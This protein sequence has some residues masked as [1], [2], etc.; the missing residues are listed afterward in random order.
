[1][2]NINSLLPDPRNRNNIN[3]KYRQRSLYLNTSNRIK[4]Y[5]SPD[6]KKTKSLQ[7]IQSDEI[8]RIMKDDPKKFD[9]FQ[10]FANPIIANLNKSEYPFDLKQKIQ[11]RISDEKIFGQIIT[12]M[13]QVF[14]KDIRKLKKISSD[15]LNKI[16][17]LK[18]DLFGK[19]KEEQVSP[20]KQSLLQKFKEFALKIKQKFKGQQGQEQQAELITDEFYKIITILQTLKQDPSS[21]INIALVINKFFTIRIG[22]IFGSFPEFKRDGPLKNL[23]NI[24]CRFNLLSLAVFLGIEPLIVLFLLLG[25]DPSLTN[26][27]NQD[28][29]YQLLFFQ[30]IFR[31]IAMNV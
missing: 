29:S 24:Q 26:Q 8:R 20:G 17:K 11:F 1:M 27:Q 16:D 2:S 28:A 7:E 25:G 10:L 12:S 23:L 30:M 31:N 18:N 9:F 6:S 5:S 3:R 15:E 21:L 14:K 4:N 19:V 22:D 13:I